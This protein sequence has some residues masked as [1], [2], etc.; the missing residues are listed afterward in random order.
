MEI[1]LFEPIVFAIA[2]SVLVVL[3][4][5]KKR[6]WLKLFAVDPLLGIPFDY[7]KM[8]PV[9]GYKGCKVGQTVEFKKVNSVYKGEIIAIGKNAKYH[10][11]EYFTIFV[12]SVGNHKFLCRFDE[13]SMKF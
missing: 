3:L 11:G 7:T 8:K 10:G 1:T 13:I 4:R 6:N 9:R 12:I 5:N 2:I